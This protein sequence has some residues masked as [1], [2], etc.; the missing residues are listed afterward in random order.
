MAD[1]QVESC[2]ELTVLYL[3]WKSLPKARSCVP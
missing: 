2:L 1:I 3:D